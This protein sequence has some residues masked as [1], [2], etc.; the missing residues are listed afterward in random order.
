MRVFAKYFIVFYQKFISPYKGFRCAYGVYYGHSSCS[1]EIMEIV[2][3]QPV[4][5]WY[6]KSKQQFEA[7]RHALSLIDGPK[8][9]R[10]KLFKRKD[11]KTKWYDCCD[12]TAACDIFDL[13]S[14]VKKSGRVVDGVDCCDCNPL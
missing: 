8:K 7:C 2:E 9:K 4:S 13:C 10:R 5:S 14:L 1:S 11:E 12:P 3:N 6:R